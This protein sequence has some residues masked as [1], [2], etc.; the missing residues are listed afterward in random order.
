M[1]THYEVLEI[2]KN[3]SPTEI[4]KAYRALARKL[5]PDK[6][7]G[8][9]EAFRSIQEAYEILSDSEKR[10]EYDVALGENPTVENSSG[11][12]NSSSFNEV[13]ATLKGFMDKFSNEDP[14]FKSA[15]DGNSLRGNIRSDLIPT[16]RRYLFE[17]EQKVID[18]LNT[19]LIAIQ[20]GLTFAL[21][22]KRNLEQTLAA[23]PQSQIHVNENKLTE[24]LNDI[25]SE[26][27]ELRNWELTLKSLL[28]EMEISDHNFLQNIWSIKQEEIT[29]I[30]DK[31][32]PLENLN[33]LLIAIAHPESAKNIQNFNA[34]LNLPIMFKT[35]YGCDNHLQEN[36]KSKAEIA[37]F[38]KQRMYMHIASELGAR[39]AQ[40][41]IT[42]LQVL[43][44][45][46]IIM[47]HSN[48]DVLNRFYSLID[49]A[50]RKQLDLAAPPTLSINQHNGHTADK[51]KY[52]Q[53]MKLILKKLMDVL[54]EEKANTQTYSAK[55]I[56][57]MQMVALC[58]MQLSNNTYSAEDRLF[59]LM[60]ILKGHVDALLM[61]K[62]ND[63][64]LLSSLLNI[65][66]SP[67]LV[68][69]YRSIIELLNENYP[70]L[71]GKVAPAPI[72]LNGYPKEATGLLLKNEPETL[73][74][75][76][77]VSESSS[78][79]K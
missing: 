67:P 59:N 30:F 25:N 41:V 38:I 54:S 8:S 46:K 57:S 17:D 3:A 51:Y 16:I 75:I 11:I 10:R 32:I 14:V 58:V 63:F 4:R 79:P 12:N 27:R 33:A 35:E 19:M 15:K 1:P 13:S 73:N 64:G 48:L 74:S 60:S 24:D 43:N 61:V 40:G 7:G 31:H 65:F 72:T 18:E 36:S 53:N 20:N 47:A 9:S 68:K 71:L 49:T 70:I 55:E 56:E 78:A 69:E 23:T 62:K 5:H 28:I 34:I 21:K 50:Y 6:E 76:T 37:S 42:P 77:S 39:I 2:N 22:V 26:I 29:T 45:S 44:Y 66:S 52:P